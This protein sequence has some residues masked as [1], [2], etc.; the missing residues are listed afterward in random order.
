MRLYFHMNNQRNRLC[1]SHNKIELRFLLASESQQRLS[2]I[3]LNV[4]GAIICSHFNENY[5]AIPK[6]ICHV[7]TDIP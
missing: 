7:H 5:P 3:Y 4:R 2:I 6:I 1:G